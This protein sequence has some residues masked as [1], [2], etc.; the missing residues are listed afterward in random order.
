MENFNPKLAAWLKNEPAQEAGINNIQIP[1]Q[2]QNV[3]WQNRYR[4]PT[5]YELDLVAHLEQ[6]FAAGAYELDELVSALNGQGLRNEAGEVWTTSNF[7]DEMARL[8]Y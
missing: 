6:A 2:T 5:R 1:G 7:Q 4:E 3:I 8:G